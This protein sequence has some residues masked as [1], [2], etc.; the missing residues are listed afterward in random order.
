MPE[1]VEKIQQQV[2][3][4]QEILDALRLEHKATMDRI[5]A[6]R[7]RL[8]E[9]EATIASE[10][11]RLRKTEEDVLASK[12]QAGQE[13]MRLKTLTEEIRLAKKE[14]SELSSEVVRARREKESV[15]QERQSTLR[16]FSDEKED[17]IKSL[18]ELR[19]RNVLELNSF[20]QQSEKVKKEIMDAEREK[21]TVAEEVEVFRKESKRLETLVAEATAL[22]NSTEEKRS[23]ILDEILQSE[24]ALSEKRTALANMEE[25][26]KKGEA[27][28]AA[29]EARIAE[30]KQKTETAK[31]GYDEAV[32]LAFRVAEREIAII[33]RENFI[34]DKYRRAGVPW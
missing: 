22:L 16:R 25:S 26:V 10:A 13:D 19:A 32:S 4:A 2:N 15:L 30:Y 14:I 1:E 8:E 18:D 17:L 28:M 3:E 6:E 31:E 29:M 24:T 11:D 23:V 27:D 21:R 34:K 20:F 5:N 12:R 33:K 7:A 9:I